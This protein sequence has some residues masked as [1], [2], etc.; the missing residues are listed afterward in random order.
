MS[1][2]LSAM[3]AKSN[4][5]R[6]RSISPNGDHKMKRAVSPIPDSLSDAGSTRKYTRRPLS[7]SSTGA[8]QTVAALQQQHKWLMQQQDNANMGKLRSASPGYRSV[9]PAPNFSKSKSTENIK[10]KQQ[11]AQISPNTNEDEVIF[12]DDVIDGEEEGDDVEEER[13]VII[14]DT[15]ARSPSINRGLYISQQ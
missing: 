9:S 11:S 4:E 5:W 3:S 1:R 8:G 15:R 2:P 14:Q 7:T 13:M 10:Q 6:T 12:D